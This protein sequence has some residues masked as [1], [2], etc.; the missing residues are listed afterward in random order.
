MKAVIDTNVVISS[1]LSPKGIRAKIIK[2][3]QD[4]Q[5][6]LVISEDIMA[7]YEKAL[8]Y[9]EVS[10]RHKMNSDQVSRVI[11][12]LRSFAT[13]IKPKKKLAVIKDD[14][15]DDKFLE[16]ASEAGAEYIISADPHLLSLEY[17]KGIQILSPSEF[18]SVIQQ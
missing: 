5:F 17:Y 1:F 6:E 16:C 8:N 12:N 2:A 14:P 10:S 18:L 15:E 3:W 4:Q 7:E 9:P 11:N 13:V